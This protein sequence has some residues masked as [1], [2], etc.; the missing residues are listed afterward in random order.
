VIATAYSELTRVLPWSLRALGYSFP[1]SD[2]ASHIITSAAA[3][4]PSVLDRIGMLP[5]REGGDNHIG[6]N[7]E[8]GCDV[9]AMHR[10]IL[11]IGPAFM[12][13]MGASVP[14]QGYICG[15]ISNVVQLEIL[16]AVLLGALDY[17]LSCVAIAKH[18]DC[19]TWLLAMRIDGA[20][21]ILQGS[22]PEDLESVLASAD[23][24]MCEAASH[25]FK[26]IGEDTCLLFGTRR[27]I[28]IP[29]E[30]AATKLINADMALERAFK[31]G[32]PVEPETLKAIYELEKLTW[33]PTSER[34]RA[35]AGFMAPAG[36][37][38]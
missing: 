9:D 24:Q 18:G 27:A 35:Q 21:H 30:L 19:A 1:V 28:D 25:G 31:S 14:A 22:N 4:D 20:R 2:R 6:I 7:V 29:T 33:A 8:G 12:D 32:I 26:A 36:G 34:S 37:A 10:S 11:E 15:S 17:G 16:P 3:I 5:R 38:A 13:F 23:L